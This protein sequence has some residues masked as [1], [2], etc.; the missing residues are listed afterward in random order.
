ML[1]APRATSI[2]ALL[3]VLATAIITLVRIKTDGPTLFTAEE[4]EP[5]LVFVYLRQFYFLGLGLLFPVLVLCFL[6]CKTSNLVIPVSIASAAVFAIWVASE[7]ILW[8]PSSYLYHSGVEPARLPGILRLILAAGLILSPPILVLLYRR[9]PILDRY[10]L[11]QFLGPF[12]LCSVGILAVWII[13]D[14]QDNGSDFFEARASFGTL[15]HLYI[16]QLPQMVV[17]ILPATLLLGLLYS[18][19]KMSKSNEI[20]SML[21]S[22]RSLVSILSP[23]LFVGIYTS[24]V[25][26]AL[27]YEWAPQAEAHKDSIL[28]DIEEQR[29]INK[30]RKKKRRIVVRSEDLA[31]ARNQVY[32]NREANRLW[33]IRYIPRDLS[34][35]KMTGVEIIERDPEGN[36][37]KAIYAEKAAWDYLE[38]NWILRSSTQNQVKI[39]DYTQLD[40]NG[41][42]TWTLE[43]EHIETGWTETPWNIVSEHLVADHL[44]VPDLGFHLAANADKPADKLA[45]FRAHWHYRWALPWNCFVVVV[46]A[47]PLGIGLSRRG[48][49]GGVAGAILLF[50]C[51]V[52]L[53]H[54]FLV[55]GQS[56]IVPAFVGAWVTNLL[57][58]AIGLFL[59]YM[60]SMNK[61]LPK[62]NP[63]SWLPS[64]GGSEPDL[65]PRSSGLQP[66]PVAAQPETAKSE[67]RSRPQR[68]T[69]R[70]SAARAR[71]SD[72]DLDFD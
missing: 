34:S 3:A 33:R 30:E 62:L 6:R 23:L 55:L 51:L 71:A 52:F 15:L 69:S 56:Q 17:M 35:K 4:T 28:D 50:F 70:S 22:G 19:G 16:V 37:S 53:S 10:L 1:T 27:N 39:F 31:L 21:S 66:A 25:C 41:N 18:L 44:G 54:L 45:P 48:V 2:L 20:V 14:L 26:L 5:E 9:A 29:R 58:L 43:E 67:E 60:R 24:V 57:L 68:R 13:Y 61:D 12:I 36:L 38:K 42:P 65:P 63:F 47:A 32:P 49:L 59:I 40:E 64:S 46:F 11:R 72:F 8:Q 7:I